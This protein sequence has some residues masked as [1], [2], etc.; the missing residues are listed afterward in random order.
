MIN[1]DSST[2]STLT[3]HKVGNK[4][5]DEG[6]KFSE[7]SISMEPNINDLLQQYFFTPFKSSELYTFCHESD[8]NL[9]E[10]YIYASKIFQDESNL[11]EQSRNIAKH[12]YAKSTHP[13]IKSGELYIA[14]F[15]GTQIGGVDSDAIGIFKSES[16]ET[17]LRIYPSGN[18]FE[19]DSEKGININKL[20]K[21]CIIFNTEKSNGYVVSIIDTTKTGD[22]AQFW[23]NDFLKVKIRED[24][25]SRTENIMSLCQNFIKA[26]PALEKI[27]KIE[28]INQTVGYLKENESFNIDSYTSQI[29]ADKVL[30]DA[31]NDFKSKYEQE[32]DV[33]IPDEFQLSA[34]AFKKS[35]RSIRSQ[36]KLDNNFKISIDGDTRYLEKGYDEEKKL[37]YYKLFFKDEQ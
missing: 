10:I 33:I 21:G 1:L 30:G 25:Y 11:Q 18:N 2:M 23:A 26:Q 24:E 31:F 15:R 6:V 9:N 34:Q 8:I 35:T 19:I 7:N 37:S 22:I 4:L 36:I 20:D 13:K 32:R 14:Y 28:I 3:L 16:K 29:L 17:Y 12:L 5:S 27:D